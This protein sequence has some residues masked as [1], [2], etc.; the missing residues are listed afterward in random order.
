LR[1]E[2]KIEGRERRT[3]EN[4]EG[5]ASPIEIGEGD[6]IEFGGVE[7]SPF[8]EEGGVPSWNEFNIF[9]GNH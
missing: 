6:G 5:A 7:E 3:R 1:E 9:R 4:E 2:G 8:V